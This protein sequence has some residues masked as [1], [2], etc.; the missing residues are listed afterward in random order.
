MSTLSIK[1]PGCGARARADI[2]KPYIQCDYCGNHFMLQGST[3]QAEALHQRLAQQAREKE[4][5][6]AQLRSLS[7]LTHALPRLRLMESRL[8]VARSS[9]ATYQE[10]HRWWH[11][12]PGKLVT[13]IVPALA[14]LVFY[15]AVSSNFTHNHG[16]ALIAG[17]VMAGLALLPTLLVRKLY[18]SYLTRRVTWGKA[19]CASIENEISNL[20]DQHDV[21]LLP[22]GYRQPE[23]IVFISKALASR[24]ANSIQEAI[25][26]YEDSRKG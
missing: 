2:T 25:T 15:M 23:S 18:I 20:K 9:L 3:A 8:D 5:L 6:E 11:S 13:G 7:D 22:E 10:K 24:R 21:D 14:F 19:A 16:E 1:C 17:V 4:G 12:L 26:Q